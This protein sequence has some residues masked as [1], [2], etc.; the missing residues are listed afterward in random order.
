MRSGEVRRPGE[1][2]TGQELMQFAATVLEPYKVPRL[3]EFS[4]ALPRTPS[5]KIQWR[6]LQEQEFA[7]Q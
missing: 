3:I 5:G 2:L 1:E 6:A 4:R 7:R